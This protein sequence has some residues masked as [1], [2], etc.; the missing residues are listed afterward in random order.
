[1]PQAPG[2]RHVLGPVA[3]P[4][5]NGILT[6]PSGGGTNTAASAASI[7]Q[8]AVA[9]GTTNNGTA[10][11]ELCIVITVAGTYGLSFG[12]VTGAEFVI[13]AVGS[14]I[15][16]NEVITKRIPAGWKYTQTVGTAA[17]TITTQRV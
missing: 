14:V 12:P 7:N 11:V 5:A 10:D 4:Y 8:S 13:L 3:V 17:G 15:S 16:L 9:S 6:Y 1:M 2:A